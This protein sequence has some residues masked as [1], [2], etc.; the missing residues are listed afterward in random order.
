MFDLETEVRRWRTHAERK[1]SLSPREVDELEDHLRARIDLEL[2]LNGALTSAQAFAAASEDVGEPAALSREFARA[3]KPRWRRL[4]AAGWAM[5]AVSWF[6]P[7]FSSDTNPVWGWQAFLLTLEW[8]ESPIETISALTNVLIVVT[9]LKI[10]GTRPPGTRWLA[11]LVT[12]AA[13]LNLHWWVSF[14]LDPTTGSWFARMT[15]LSVGYWAW[16]GS[17]ICIAAALWLRAREW[18]SARPEKA[19][20]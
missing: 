7:V 12:G 6:L 2:E 10:G 15:A 17:F 11:W 1:S 19:P 9:L 20:A 3:G 13:A 18:A 4:L 16:A 8:A 5:F 14:L